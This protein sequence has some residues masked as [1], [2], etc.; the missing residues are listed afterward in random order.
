MR[1]GPGV[2]TGVKGVGLVMSDKYKSDMHLTQEL[3]PFY[4]AIL[5][6]RWWEHQREPQIVKGNKFTTV[7]KNAKTDRGICI[8]PT[9]NV[10]AQLGL[11]TFL[12][13]RLKRFGVDLFDQSR[14]QYLAKVAMR[15]N[16]CTVDLSRASDSLCIA[17][18]FKLLPPRWF[19]LFDLFRSK[20]TTMPSGED[21][22]LEKFS[23]MG[24]G[25]TFELESLIFSSIVYSIVPKAEHHLCGIYGDDLIFPRNYADDI[26][27]RLNFLGFSVNSQKSFLAGNF[28][29]SCGSDWFKGQ[30]VRP[31]YLRK[32]DSSSK[33]PYALQI[34]NSLRH[35]AS[36]Q[37]DGEFC[38]MRFKELWLTLRSM[39]G[40]K[41]KHA[42]GPPAFGD[43]LLHVSEDELTVN[44]NR[45]SVGLEGRYVRYVLEKPV[46]RYRAD[47]F[48]YLA[49]FSR[50]GGSFSVSYSRYG[51]PEKFVFGESS[52]TKGFQPRRGFLR[53]P[54][55]K[56]GLTNE[57]LAPYWV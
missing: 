48:T 45:S 56:W 33:A 10:Y 38:D 23:S 31:F 34:A 53:S 12:K 11:G 21:V 46:Q 25:F 20:Y 27:E 3:I 40:G 29:E 4:K 36:Q 44:K 37:Y 7:P 39:I 54:V 2:T 50:A 17:A 43:S 19:E 9:L 24:N 28:F 49:A 1:F 35:F 51:I 8:E 52:M 41:W 22:T 42:E 14:N 13:S 32:G 15:K 47:F 26:I 5:G 30:S 57:P 18:V 55:L 16:L 6:E